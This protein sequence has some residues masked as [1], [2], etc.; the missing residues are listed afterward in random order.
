[1]SMLGSLCSKINL[2]DQLSFLESGVKLAL[3]NLLNQRY[4]TSISLGMK[5]KDWSA[6]YEVVRK[7]SG[8][9]H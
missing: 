7:Q 6:I 1:M 8:L 3:V 9:K 4:D 5:D 2:M